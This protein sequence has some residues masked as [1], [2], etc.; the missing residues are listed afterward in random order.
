MKMENPKSSTHHPGSSGATAVFFFWFAAIAPI[1][2]PVHAQ[3]WKQTSAPLDFWGSVASSSDGN[4]LIA[5]ATQ[6]FP[7]PVHISTNSGVDWKTN[8]MPSSALWYAVASSTN[9]SVL[10]AVSMDSI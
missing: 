8:A 2:C 9:G 10:G 3:D 7:V 4:K 6:K 5:V 1:L